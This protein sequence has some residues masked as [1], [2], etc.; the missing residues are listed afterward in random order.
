M[1]DL[2]GLKKKKLQE[3]EQQLIQQQNESLKEQLELQQQIEYLESVV[4]KYLAK[5]SI[6]RYG[7]LKA[8]HPEKAIQVIT[9]IAQA[10]QS[11]N[12][13]EKITD[14]EFKLLLQKLQTKKEF[15]IRR[16]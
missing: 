16:I 1:N 8:A 5:E 2:E 14:A 7:N 15:K 6:S 11:N 13:T 9:L 12:I 10:I 4:K 3:L